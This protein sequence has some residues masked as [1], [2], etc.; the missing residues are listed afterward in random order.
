MRR[1]CSSV[2]GGLSGS[3]VAAA[4]NLASSPSSMGLWRKRRAHFCASARR[5]SISFLSLALSSSAFLFG[6]AAA[7]PRTGPAQANGVI[8]VVTQGIDIDV[9]RVVYSHNG[10]LAL[11]A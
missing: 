7:L 6:I 11:C 5:R 1:S 10:N 2:S 4:I 9:D 3:D 8:L